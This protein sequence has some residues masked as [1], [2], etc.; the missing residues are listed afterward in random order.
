MDER[1]FRTSLTCR[2]KQ[3]KRADSVS[4]EVIERNIGGSIM[5]WLSG[6]VDYSSWFQLPE[7]FKYP[8]SIADIQFVVREIMESIDKPLLAPSRIPLWAEKNCPLVAIDAMNF[9]AKI[10][11]KCDDFGTDEP[12]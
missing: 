4:I 7:K 1:C 9:E 3:I 5:R 11:E 8:L 10:M 12:R 6:S 2:F